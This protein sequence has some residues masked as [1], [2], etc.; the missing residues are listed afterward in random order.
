MN[1]SKHGSY[2]ENMVTT[3]LHILLYF[4]G[5]YVTLNNGSNFMKS[6]LYMLNP[7]M[8]VISQSQDALYVKPNHVTPNNET[9][10]L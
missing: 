3:V 9:V 4:D 5:L 2:F 6:W 1:K 8:E 10:F 7:T